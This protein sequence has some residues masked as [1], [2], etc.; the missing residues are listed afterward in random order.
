MEANA[1]RVPLQ[2][3]AKAQNFHCQRCSFYNTN[4][5][6]GHQH[7]VHRLKQH[8]MHTHRGGAFSMGQ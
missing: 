5:L 6:L 2:A 4:Q 3:K 8:S 1:S 7:K